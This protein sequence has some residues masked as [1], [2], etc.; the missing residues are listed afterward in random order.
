MAGGRRNEPEGS[1]DEGAVKDSASMKS[2]SVLLCLGFTGWGTLPS[3]N[4]TTTGASRPG[5][6]TFL[7]P[8]SGR[9]TRAGLVHLHHT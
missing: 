7:A 9:P 6:G 1:G 2:S 5:N 3:I 8:T 4:P